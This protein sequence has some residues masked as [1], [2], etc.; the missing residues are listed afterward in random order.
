MKQVKDIIQ[1]LEGRTDADSR[2]LLY[3]IQETD[4][5]KVENIV[6]TKLQRRLKI[7]TARAT[8]L[9]CNYDVVD[10]FTLELI[11]AN[12][13]QPLTAW[14]ETVTAKT[15]ANL[16]VNRCECCNRVFYAPRPRKEK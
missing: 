13:G 7:S 1:W 14:L 9:V 2:G 5:E 6:I 12:L 16:S 4:N 3:W 8:Q 11:E 15:K 10:P